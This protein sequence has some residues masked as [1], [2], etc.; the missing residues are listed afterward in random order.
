[1]PSHDKS[2]SRNV[3]L[4]ISGVFATIYLFL[5]LAFGLDMDTRIL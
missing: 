4:C 2:S 1:M 3:S 5:P